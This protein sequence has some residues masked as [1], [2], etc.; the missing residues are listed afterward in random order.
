MLSV[1]QAFK[2][3]KVNHSNVVHQATHKNEDPAIISKNICSTHD[4]NRQNAR[5]SVNNACVPLN[6]HMA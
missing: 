4:L 6:Y 2:K 5:F 3:R 1:V